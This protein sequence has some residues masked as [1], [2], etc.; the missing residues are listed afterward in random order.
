M[1]CD[2]EA[3]VIAIE[4]ATSGR[5]AREQ[6]SSGGCVALASAVAAQLD[7]N[8]RAFRKVANSAAVNVSVAC[9]WA[10]RRVNSRKRIKRFVQCCDDCGFTTSVG[11]SHCCAQFVRGMS[12]GC[13]L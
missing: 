8:Y 9:W 11:E 4:K 12:R 1:P 6:G 5:S 7:E 10:A 2:V 13:E 3:W